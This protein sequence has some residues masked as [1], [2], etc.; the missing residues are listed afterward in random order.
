MDVLISW[1]NEWQEDK[2]AG[3]P[4]PATGHRRALR[5]AVIVAVPYV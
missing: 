3:A 5:R 1:H 2:K 4:L